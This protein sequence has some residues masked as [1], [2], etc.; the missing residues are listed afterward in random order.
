MAVNVAEI[1]LLIPMAVATALPALIASGDPAVAPSAPARAAGAHDRHVA[2]VA[3]RRCV[4]VPAAA[5]LRAEYADSVRTAAVAAARHLGLAVITVVSN[6]L[7]GSSSPGLGSLGPFVALV[8]GLALDFLLIPTYGAIGRGDR[9]ERGLLH[10]RGGL[11]VPLSPRRR[12]PPRGARARDPPTRA[13]SSSP[14]SG[15]LR[16]SPGARWWRP[17]GERSRRA[18]SVPRCR[19]RARQRPSG[20]GCGEPERSARR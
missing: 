13:S 6:A 15:S 14:P 7:L 4:P 2:T 11:A 12:L 19:P 17:A 9:L 18:P 20:R 8:V 1:A 16:A 5:R 10:R 3:S